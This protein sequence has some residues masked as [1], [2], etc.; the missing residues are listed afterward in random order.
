MW[1]YLSAGLAGEVV[2]SPERSVWHPVN[3]ACGAG[4]WWQP[5]V[6]EGCLACMYTLPVEQVLVW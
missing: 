4:M 3:P 2:Q 5:A 1:A 6:T